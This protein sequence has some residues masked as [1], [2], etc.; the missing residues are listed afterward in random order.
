M[1]GGGG[2]RTDERD[3]GQPGEDAHRAAQTTDRNVEQS[4]HDVGIEMC[5]GA[6]GEFGTCVGERHRL[7]VGAHRGHDLE[8]VRD[9]DDRRRSWNGRPG[10]AAR[11]ARAVPLLVVSADGMD[12]LTEPRR[13]GC[14]ERLSVGRMRPQNL[15]FP[16]GGGALLVQDLRGDGDLSDVVDKSRPL[17]LGP[18]GRAEPE[19][20]GDEV[21]EESYPLGV[22]ACPAVVVTDRRREHDELLRRESS[23]V[24]EPVGSGL[25][26]F[27]SHASAASCPESEPEPV[28]HLVGKQQREL[29]KGGKGQ[30]LAGLSIGDR[31]HDEGGHD[32]ERDAHDNRDGGVRARK[33]SVEEKGCT[34]RHHDRSQTDG[35]PRR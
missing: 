20:D 10:Q 22:T 3:V 4:P 12:P 5:P 9:G 35:R 27:A 1:D 11:V 25:L 14:G 16:L 13:D 19:L 6:A 29:Q 24:G 8:G 21:G 34:R 28:R 33:Q 23:I 15:P 2:Q 31:E 7:L 26:Q 17:K 18:L 30:E 32:D